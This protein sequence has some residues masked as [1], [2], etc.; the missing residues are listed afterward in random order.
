MKT[1][2]PLLDELAEGLIVREGAP[3]VDFDADDV[4]VTA[5]SREALIHELLHI[6]LLHWKCC[7]R[8]INLAADHAL[9]PYTGEKFDF[10]PDLPQGKSLEFYSPR[11]GG[12]MDALSFGLPFERHSAIENKVLNATLPFKEAAERCVQ[13]GT[14]RYATPSTQ[15]A[16]IYHVQNPGAD[17]SEIAAA[18]TSL[19]EELRAA[20]FRTARMRRLSWIEWLY[21]HAISKIPVNLL[22]CRSL[23]LCRGI[24]PLRTRGDE[25]YMTG[26]DSNVVL[27]GSDGQL[28][29]GVLADCTL[30][31]CSGYVFEMYRCQLNESDIVARVSSN[32][33]LR[34][35]TLK[36]GCEVCNL[37]LRGAGR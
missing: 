16:S 17:G 36:S 24:L 3:S 23:A 8:N 30:Y 31:N 10:S 20:V 14:L 15:L 2:E 7:G 9:Y 19:D 33:V 5:D 34:N 22:N 29:C 32:C 37:Q 21:R 27:D 26:S 35:S 12:G 1:G 11:L 28:L 6:V 13:T 18:I 4:I 25:K